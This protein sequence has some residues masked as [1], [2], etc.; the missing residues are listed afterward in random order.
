MYIMHIISLINSTIYLNNLLWK[1]F[2]RQ[3]FM[4]IIEQINW[5]KRFNRMQEN[6]IYIVIKF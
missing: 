2:R 3:Y 6:I 1:V 5:T 4:L